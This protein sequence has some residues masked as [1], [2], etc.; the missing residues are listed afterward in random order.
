MKHVAKPL[1]ISALL[2]C[3]IPAGPTLAQEKVSTEGMSGAWAIKSYELVGANGGRSAVFGDS[4]KGTL[5]VD[6]KGNYSLVLIDPRRP[7][8]S[9]DRTKSNDAELA[10]ATKGLIAQFGR[11]SMDPSSGVLIRRIGG[12]LNPNAEG[13]E[14]KLRASLS[15]DELTITQE[16]SGA[17]GGGAT[18]QVFVRV[19]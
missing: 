11:L 14:E 8:W 6:A 17:T 5:V 4:P 3:F 7:K 10:A 9:A 15:G 2:A 18:V 12:A 13:R 19:K 1:A 16:N